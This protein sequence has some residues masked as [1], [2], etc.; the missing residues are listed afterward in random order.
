VTAD[1]VLD[2]SGE[3]AGV[4]FDISVRI[5]ASLNRDLVENFYSMVVAVA[6]AQEK[7]RHHRY[8]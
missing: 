5:T 4:F 2:R 6:L 7:D 1:K 8:L 3:A